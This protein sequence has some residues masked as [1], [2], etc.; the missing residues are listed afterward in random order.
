MGIAVSTLVFGRCGWQFLTWVRDADHSRRVLSPCYRPTKIFLHLSAHL[1]WLTYSVCMTAP[2][3][4]LSIQTPSTKGLDLS[5]PKVY[6]LARRIYFKRFSARVRWA[7][8]DED[9]GFQHVCLC[10]ISR[11]RGKSRYDASRSSLSN[12]LYLAMTGI[13]KNIADSA[14]RRAVRDAGVG[15]EADVASDPVGSAAGPVTERGMADLAVEMEIPMGVL[16]ALADGGDVF[17]AALDAGLDFFA[18]DELVSA[19]GLR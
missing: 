4:A 10:L 1:C 3:S 17:C 5:D 7:G 18:A 12:Y 16:H 14:R 11:Q 19:L 9:D 13:S 6:S 8:V 15:G 2:H